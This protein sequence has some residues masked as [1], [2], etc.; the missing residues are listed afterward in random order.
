MIGVDSPWNLTFSVQDVDSLVADHRT[1]GLLGGSFVCIVCG[2]DSI[3]T[4][5]I[6]EWSSLLDLTSRI[7][8]SVSVTRTNGS[9]L[10][11]SASHRQFQ[12]RIPAGRFPSIILQ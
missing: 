1:A 11:V 12:S 9:Q 7:S 10:N 3:C 5:C 8:Q 6:D 4:L 2:T